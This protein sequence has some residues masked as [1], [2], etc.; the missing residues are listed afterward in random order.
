MTK[1]QQLLANL[2]TLLRK[3]NATKTSVRKI[4]KDTKIEEFLECYGIIG[5]ILRTVNN[6][7]YRL[8]TIDYR[9]NI[10]QVPLLDSEFAKLDQD[11]LNK[12]ES[13][14]GNVPIAQ[15]LK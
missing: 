8:E 7:S 3:A 12:L 9:G 11:Y 15:Q 4:R 1:N 10:N 5:E 6:I 14:I 13:L 2:R